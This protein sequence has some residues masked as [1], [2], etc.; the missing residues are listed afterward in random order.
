MAHEKRMD[1]SV[2]GFEE[3]YFCGEKS[4]CTPSLWLYQDKF[5]IELR[6]IMGW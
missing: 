5:Q 2:R 1:Y 6:C 4:G 3:F